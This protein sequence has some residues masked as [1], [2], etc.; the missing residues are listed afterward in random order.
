MSKVVFFYKTTNSV[1]TVF[2]KHLYTKHYRYVHV[3]DVKTSQ[4]P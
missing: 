2:Y 4:K 1:T 3:K